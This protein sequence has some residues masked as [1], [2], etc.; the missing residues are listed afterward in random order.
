MMTARIVAITG[1][2]FAYAQ[3]A[4]AQAPAN[5]S[6]ATAGEIKVERLATLE[7]PWGVAILPGGRLLITEKPG[8]LRILDNGQLSEPVQG[9]PEV[10]YRSQGGLLDVEADPDFANNKHVYL[11]YTEAA[12]QQASDIRDTSDVRFGKLDVTDNIIRGGA[13]ARARLEGNALQDLQV[14]WRQTPKTIGRG[15][16]GNRIIFA[17]DGTMFITSGDRMRFE[18]AQ[19]LASN[20][21]KFVRINRDGSIPDNNPFAGQEGALGDI[22]SY[23]HR[24]TLAAAIDP[25]TGNLWGFEMGPLGGDEVNLVK[26]GANYG[27]P[28]VSNGDHYGPPESTLHA[29]IPGHLT[30]KDYEAPVRTWTPV[31][32]PSGAAFYTGDLF[33]KWKGSVLV[34]GLSTKGIVRLAIAG[35]SVVL[36]ERIDMGLRIRD[37]VQAPD[38]AVLLLVDDQ[39]GDVLR[40]TPAAG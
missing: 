31:I 8:R 35:E 2:S 5:V 15:H 37:V 40:L 34:G 38:G 24:N 17:G 6:S 26:R 25:S 4:F 39:Q 21:G 20:L 18:P 11:S 10:V 1:L 32:S 23:G 30:S 28:M 9:V 13:V 14:I 22:W 7:F 27:W 3:L 19:S 36:E 12:E 16:F 33:P 29:S